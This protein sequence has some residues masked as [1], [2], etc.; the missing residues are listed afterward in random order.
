M[1]Q[2]DSATCLLPCILDLLDCGGV[3]VFTEK[4]V[5]MSPMHKLNDYG[6][7]FLEKDEAKNI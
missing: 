5:I 4:E 7:S 3:E 6:D 1:S 2:T